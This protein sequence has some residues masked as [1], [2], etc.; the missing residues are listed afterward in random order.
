MEGIAL[1]AGCDTMYVAE[2]TVELI[3]MYLINGTKLTS[4]PSS[5]A[6]VVKHGPEG[7]TVDKNNHVFVINE[8]LPT[9]LLEYNQGRE[10][11]RKEINYTTDL[12]D[13]FYEAATDCFWIVSDESQEVI[14]ISRA[15]ALL[16]EW[17]VPFTKGEGLTIVQNRIYIINDADGKLYVFEKPE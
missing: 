10:V 6:T 15:G 13:I 7:V 4:F 9:M 8:K 14:K 1:S 16:G 2:E 11:S 5:V 12:S 17:S 3:S